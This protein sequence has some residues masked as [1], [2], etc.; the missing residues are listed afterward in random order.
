[1]RKNF[2]GL[3]ADSIEIPGFAS[4]KDARERLNLILSAMTSGELS[5]A[6]GNQLINS[7]KLAEEIESIPELV[8]QLDE[9]KEKLKS[10]D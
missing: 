4:A 8:Q 3:D 6:A 7:M 1:M 9:L 2:N 10:G 5:V